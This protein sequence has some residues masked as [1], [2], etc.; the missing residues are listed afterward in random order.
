MARLLHRSQG[1]QA[2]CSWTCNA[3]H[4]AEIIFG[5]HRIIYPEE[6]SMTY[7]EIRTRSH[8]HLHLHSFVAHTCLAS[9]HCTPSL[10]CHNRVY[11]C[12][13]LRCELGTYIKL[14]YAYNASLPVSTPVRGWGFA[15]AVAV[16]T[17]TC[18]LDLRLDLRLDLLLDPLPACQ[19]LHPMLIP[20]RD[21]KAMQ[22][23]YLHLYAQGPSKVLKRSVFRLVKPERP[24]RPP[25]KTPTP[26]QLL[27]QVPM[28]FSPWRTYVCRPNPTTPYH[29]CFVLAP[30]IPFLCRQRLV[31]QCDPLS[32][33]HLCGRNFAS[34]I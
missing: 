30:H 7:K 13:R 1:L 3:R 11:P 25:N 27:A 16:S 18:P 14:P 34:K 21:S 15:L 33:A 17:D 32:S 8:P 2:T 23:I 10:A 24:E 26:H 6:L 4:A 20:G 22:P 12:L 9:S 31:V 28:T 29:S 5:A 19:L